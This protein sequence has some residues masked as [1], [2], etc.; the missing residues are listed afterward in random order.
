MDA[1]QIAFA[2]AVVSG[3]SHGDAYKEAGYPCDGLT[4]AQIARRGTSV[5]SGIAVSKYIAELRAETANLGLWT[6]EQ[7]LGELQGLYR[8]AKSAITVQNDDGNVMPGTYNH[9]AAGVALKCLDTVSRMCGFDAPQQVQNT[10]TV[11][12]SEDIAKYGK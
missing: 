10:V 11:Q 1:R 6:R 8:D 5:A 3:K 7:V 12:F 2:E 4:D 9:Q